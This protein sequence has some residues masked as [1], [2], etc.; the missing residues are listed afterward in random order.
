[1]RP[2]MDKYHDW[3]TGQPIEVPQDGCPLE[4]W[5]RGD[6]GSAFG[7]HPRGFPVFVP[8]P[9]LAQ[10][11]EY[12]GAD[13][14][15]VQRSLEGDFHGRRIEETL[16]L[17][18]EA[19]P[20]SAQA[21]RLLDIGCGEGHI[22]AR[23]HAAFPNA[24]ISAFDYS[25]SAIDRAVANFAEIDFAVAD[26]YH[27]PYAPDYFDAV[28]CNNLWEHVP[29]PLS[30]L[31]AI[32]RVLRPGG[33]LIVSTPSRYRLGNALR[34][35]TGRP[36]GFMSTAHVTEYSVGQVIEQLRYG[37]FETLRCGARQLRSAGATSARDR[38]RS[39][40]IGVLDG[41][42]R[43]LGSH[44]SWEGTVFFLARKTSDASA[45]SAVAHE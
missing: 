33:H 16:A 6:G 12:E 27:P 38:L 25:I 5:R 31:A 20:S 24:E 17:L 42:T 1:M 34:A 37:G 40:V 41:V 22:T 19:L 8:G 10:S 43:S 14:Y 4:A 30:L 23:I 26:A 18:E 7:I 44:H 29:D 39:L 11:D 21:P 15:H 2:R 3:R 45:G 9:L 35:L 36:V 13:P 28:V 32:R